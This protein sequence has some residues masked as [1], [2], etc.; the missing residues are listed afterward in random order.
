MAQFDVY[1]NPI[2]QARVAY[3]FLLVLQS[4]V[5]T[6]AREHIVAP[7]VERARL[8]QMA[9]RLTPAVDIEGVEHVALIPA[10]ANMPNR[11][12]R[13]P[14]CCLSSHRPAILAAIDY[15]FFGV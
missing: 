7:L 10:L 2:I 3:P 14:V 8:G 6:G 13:K 11:D 5:A 9:G 4:N 15:L 12:L 1:A